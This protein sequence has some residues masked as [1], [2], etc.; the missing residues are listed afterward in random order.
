MFAQ[1]LKEQFNINEPI[2]TEEIMRLFPE[3]SR[4]QVFR[5]INK[6]EENKEIVQFTKGVYYIPKMTK[7]GLSTITSDD[8]ARKRYIGWKEDIYGV[9]SGIKLLNT[10]SVTTQMPA[11]IEIV[12]NNEATR[13]REITIRNRRFILKKSRVEIN[14]ENAAAYTVLQLFNE[15]N[16]ESELNQYASKRIAE[17]VGL[18]G[19]TKTQLLNLAV[20]FP[21]RTIQRLLRSDVF[22]E[23]A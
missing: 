20:N 6:A 21:G 12:T 4:M 18:S 1:R 15:L 13:G 8:V 14:R 17:Y 19:V 23:I 5:F 16:D 9:V 11:V 2:F 10:F 7:I 22:N 3:Y